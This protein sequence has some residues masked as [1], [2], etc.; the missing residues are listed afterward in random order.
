[1]LRALLAATLA[2]GGC[3]ATATQCLQTPVSSKVPEEALASC[4]QALGAEPERQDLFHRHV[5]L[6]RVRGRY[7][8]IARW[9]RRVLEQDKKR[10]DA[11]YNLAFA[12]RK[13]GKCDKAL[14]TYLAYAEAAPEDPDPYY[15]MGLCYLDLKDHESA[16]RVFGAYIAKEKRESQREWVERARVQI[17]ALGS[18]TPLAAAPATPA[19]ATPAPATPAPATPAPATPAPASP[20]APAPATPAPATPPAPAPAPA[21]RPAP[22]PSADCSVHE[23]AFRADPFATSAYDQYADC[24]LKAGRAADV[25]KHIR[26]ALRDNPDWSRGWLHLGR[27]FKAQGDAVQAKAA[28]A[29]AC[30][31][32]VAEA[33]GL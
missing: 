22:A 18:G 1:M 28:F 25:V 3:S 20:A 24:A 14:K 27:A 21:P 23:K 7:T 12:Q 5:N 13:L 26:M 4:E 30:A 15:G 11:L 32:S 8:E 6:L 17:A 9:S 2:L 10:T 16:L 33:C 29:K 31:A 19:P